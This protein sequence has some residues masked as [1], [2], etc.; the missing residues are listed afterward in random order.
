[1]ADKDTDTTEPTE[2]P[3]TAS[4]Q[5][6]TVV[7]NPFGPGVAAERRSASVSA[8]PGV[9]QRVAALERVLAQVAEPT[10]DAL[11]GGQ[12]PE[13]AAEIE[14]F[15]KGMGLNGRVNALRRGAIA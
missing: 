11:D 2:K 6:S 1:M 7:A 14:A 8:A 4:V 10:P 15:A 13:Q 5:S 3:R 12:S 9:S